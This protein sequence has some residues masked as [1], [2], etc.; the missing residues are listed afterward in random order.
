MTKSGIVGLLW[1]LLLSTPS[2]A[3]TKCDNWP[4]W[5]QKICIRS[6]QIIN[7]GDN[8]LVLSGYAWHNRHYYTSEKINSYNE[9]E[10]GAGFGRGFYDEDYDWHAFFGL[11]FS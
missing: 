8:A 7:E 3:V 11:A 9:S 4:K 1:L 2:F 10:W 6:K 5:F